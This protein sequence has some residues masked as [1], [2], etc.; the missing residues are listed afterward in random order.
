[1]AG[2]FD[3]AKLEQVRQATDIVELVQQSVPLK[4]VGSRFRGLCPFHNEKTPSFYV[5]PAMQIFKCFGCG[6]GGDVF[7]FFMKRE[8]VGFPEAVK[9]L[10]EKAGITFEERP[11]PRRPGEIDKADLYKANAWAMEVYARLLADS[12]ACQPARDYLVRRG[13]N[14]ESIETFRLGAAPEAWD[15]LLRE[16]QR[17]GLGITP[18][19]GLTPAALAAAG[20]VAPRQNGGGFYDRFRN[21][22][23][24]PIVDTLGRC[25]GFGGRTL[26]DDPA[27]YINSPESAIFSKGRGVFGLDVAKEA[28]QKSG[29]VVVVEGYMDALMP[30][31]VGVGNVVATLGTALTADQVRLLRRYAQEVVLVFDSDAAGEAA[32]DRSL[33]VFL[34]E[35]VSL[36]VA[37]VPAGKD[38]CDYCLAEGGDAFRKVLDA[39]VPALEHKFR[40][41]RRRMGSN[42][43]VETRRRAAEEL[44]VAIATGTGSGAVDPLRRGMIIADLAKLTDIPAPDLHAK[45]EEIRRSKPKRRPQPGEAPKLAGGG[46]NF[47]GGGPRRMPFDEGP[48]GTGVTSPRG[49]PRGG[50]ADGPDA[51]AATA[52]PTAMAGSV[53]LDA[54]LNAERWVLGILLHHPDYFASVR[55]VISPDAF[56]GLGMA[57]LAKELFAALDADAENSADAGDASDAAGMSDA[58]ESSDAAEPSG[59]ASDAAEPPAAKA[60]EISALAARLSRE[61]DGEALI[62][63]MHDLY[64]LGESQANPS[65]AVEEAVVLIRRHEAQRVLAEQKAALDKLPPDSPEYQRLAH[66][67]TRR[68]DNPRARPKISGG[69][70]S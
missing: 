34:S 53:P 28:I 36:R 19:Q 10:G 26:G 54:R 9:T 50:P 1:L 61:P 59:A 46:T 49:G 23:M 47:N 51:S 21:R 41:V 5:N 29:R 6:A 57:R 40:L 67:L 37:H 45:L 31:Q 35:A 56:R 62:S 20:L 43:S 12:P 27:K 14:D 39:A 52:S 60:V 22:V 3:D 30:H 2:T 8:G 65:A 55:E 38:P 68:G 4:R 32:A 11:R 48:G 58:A 70:A 69:G 25:V 42:D 13:V 15:T 7:S 16:L 63:L 24:F 44:L 64:A 33:E 17:P 18:P 66:R